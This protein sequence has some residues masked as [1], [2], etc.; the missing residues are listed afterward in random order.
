MSQSEPSVLEDLDTSLVES[1]E[2]L[3]R[4]SQARASRADCFA[5]YTA[6]LWPTVSTAVA[7]ADSTAGRL[8]SRMVRLVLE[9]LGGSV[10]VLVAGPSKAPT[11]PGVWRLV[12]ALCKTGQWP[13]ANWPAVL[14]ATAK[15]SKWLLTAHEASANPV[16][17]AFIDDA[18]RLNCACVCCSPN[19]KMCSFAR[20]REG[21]TGCMTTSVQS[22]PHMV[23]FHGSPENRF[24]SGPRTAPNKVGRPMSSTNFPCKSAS[25]WATLHAPFLK[26]VTDKQGSQPLCGASKLRPAPQLQRYCP[27]FLQRWH[28]VWRHC[29]SSP[30]F[31]GLVMRGQW[32]SY[33]LP[34]VCKCLQFPASEIPS[35][36]CQRPTRSSAGPRP[37]GCR[38]TVG[39]PAVRSC[40]VQLGPSE[41]SAKEGFGWY[42]LCCPQGAC[43]L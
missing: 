34:A 12:A 38:R 10:S 11:A 24:Y 17:D 13:E 23:H 7:T 8:A 15:A 1:I 20:A 19:V 39:C 33:Y 16:S 30:Q 3:L 42:C 36:G 5:A 14:Q 18:V 21:R 22:Q 40:A 35:K 9:T 43:V 6:A 2:K 37:R 32:R 27:G 4:W 29:S 25:L 41:N 28:Q 31:G 26:K